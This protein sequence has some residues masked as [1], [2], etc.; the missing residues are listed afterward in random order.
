MLKTQTITNPIGLDLTW[1]HSPEPAH[2]VMEQEKVD[3]LAEA[4]ERD[5]WQGPPIVADWAL[6]AA[7]QDRAYTGAHRLAAWREAT[8]TS[9]VPC[10]FIEDLAEKYGLDYEGILDDHGRDG[11]E[12]ASYVMDQMPVEVCEAYGLD[13]GGPRW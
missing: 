13:L 8:G 4:M 12:A 11:I 1:R 5:G 10:V 7:G 9:P 6:A 2:E 3:R